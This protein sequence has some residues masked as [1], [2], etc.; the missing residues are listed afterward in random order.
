MPPFGRRGRR[1]KFNKQRFGWFGHQRHGKCLRVPGQCTL[2]DIPPGMQTKILGFSPGIPKGRQAH[3]QSYGLT[4]GSSVRVIQQ[5][6]ITVVQVEHLELALEHA[7]AQKIRVA[8]VNENN[9]SEDAKS[10]E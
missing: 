8:A 2:M 4:P 3:L 9:Q 7:L 10:V 1:R 6:P 5:S